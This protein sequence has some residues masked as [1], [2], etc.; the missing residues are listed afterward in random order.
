MLYVCT[1]FHENILGVNIFISENNIH[2]NYYIVIYINI[3]GLERKQYSI[4]GS[5]PNHVKKYKWQISLFK[6]KYSLRYRHSNNYT[7]KWLKKI[8]IIINFHKRTEIY[9]I[10]EVK[11]KT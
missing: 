4:F 3:I 8:I 9:L 2:G 11:Y 6:S 1:L 10:Q 5:S 7:Q